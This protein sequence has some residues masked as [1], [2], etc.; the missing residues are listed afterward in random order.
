MTT[1]RL[2]GYPLC[3]LLSNTLFIIHITRWF[4]SQVFTN[5][6]PFKK[7]FWMET[8][9]PIANIFCKSWNTG[10]WNCWL[11]PPNR[12]NQQIKPHPTRWQY[13]LMNYLALSYCTQ[14]YSVAMWSWFVRFHKKMDTHQLAT[15]L[16]T[17]RLFDGFLKPIFH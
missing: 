7:K 2:E 13:P 3:S 5:K 6:V 12:P 14:S 8:Y 17:S 16:C 9:I 1:K 15:T 4:K 11:S 10:N